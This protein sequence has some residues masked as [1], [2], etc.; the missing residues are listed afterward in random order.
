MTQK[1]SRFVIP[2]GTDLT[3]DAD[4]MPALRGQGFLSKK[5]PTWKTET[6]EALSGR[7][8]NRQLW[9]YPRWQFSMDHEFINNSAS[10]PDLKKMF[11][12][13]N[14]KRGS[15]KQFLYL[16]PEDS[17][18]TDAPVAVGNGTATQFQLTRTLTYGGITFTEPV[19]GFFGTPVIKLNG[20]PTVAFTMNEYGLVTFTSAPGNGVVITWTGTFFFVCKFDEDELDIS[21]F[22]S[23]FWEQDGLSFTSVK[24]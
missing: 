15:Y 13:F 22:A 8:S 2:S 16:D 21:Q 11:T 9:S 17:T 24:K 23:K 12:F 18:A 7:E 3:T 6:K 10:L 4:V 20:T 19:Q 14:S 5:T 1:P